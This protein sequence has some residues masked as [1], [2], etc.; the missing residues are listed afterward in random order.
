M[1][2]MNKATILLLLGG[3][4][5]LFGESRLSEASMYCNLKK[6]Q[7]CIVDWDMS[8]NDYDEWGWTP[9]MWAV[10]NDCGPVTDYLLS[11]GANPNLRTRKSYGSMYKG[12]TAIM[13]AAYYDKVALVDQ[14]LKA[15]ADPTL[16]DS[17][18]HNALDCATK[19]E[20]GSALPMLKKWVEAHPK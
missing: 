5:A 7:K 8:V 19:S 1:H 2:F 15:G 9:F 14:L 11:K 18:G 3:S 13:M 6:V 12:S 16:A 17:E 20:T 4:M 10:Y